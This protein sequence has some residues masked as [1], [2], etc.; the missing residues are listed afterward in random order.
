VGELHPDT[1]KRLGVEGH[2]VAVA[3][4]DI[5]RLLSLLPSDDREAPVRRTL[6]VEQDFAVVVAEETPVAEVETTLT[7][8]SGPLVTSVRLF[9]VYRG[10]S[11]GD[12]KKSLAFRVTFTAPD[13]SLTDQDIAKFRP[14]IEKALKQVGGEL[15]A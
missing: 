9:D 12:G 3:E 2:R 6:P 4:I 7:R 8:A 5:D 14:K 13:R 1:A 15:R 10:A 11:I